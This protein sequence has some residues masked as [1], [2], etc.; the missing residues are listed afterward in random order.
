M[1]EQNHGSCGD[2]GTSLAGLPGGLK[3]GETS[4]HTEFLARREV[5]A[6][7]IYTSLQKVLQL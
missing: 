2:P 5:Q 4:V 6:A 1:H 3:P 7:V